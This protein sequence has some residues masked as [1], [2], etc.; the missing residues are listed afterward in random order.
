MKALVMTGPWALE[1]AEIADPA[2]GPG[3]VVVR[4]T[5]TGICGSDFHGFTGDTGRR[6][7]GQVM[8]HETVG[9]VEWVG[10]AVTDPGLSPGALVTINP[11]LS[12]D[13][14]EVCAAGAEQSC[15]NRTVIGVAP[16][17][18]SAFAERVVVRASNVVPLAA[19]LDPDLGALVEPLA[20]GYHAAVRGACAPADRVLVI[21]GGPIGQACLLA[22][23]RLGATAV[24]VS[25]V[26]PLRRD[27]C[28]SF[29]ARV[30]DPLA[31]ARAEGGLGAAVAEALGGKATLVIDAVGLTPTVRDA[32]EASVF[33][34]R[35]VL[36]GMGTP[37]VE[38][39]AYG[40]STE[41]RSLIG[42]FCYSREHF[43]AT[44]T[45]VGE[46]TVPLGRLIDGRVGYD[47]AAAAFTDLAKGST[48]ASKILVYPGGVPTPGESR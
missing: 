40:I 24:A 41:E 5:A 27:L 4:I 16:Q 44:A 2:P 28:A 9:Y 45:W 47:G 25:D 43:A 32:I 21:G 8:G 22:A 26:N 23:Q 14:C 7:A 38:L 46:T 42:S 10:A 35:I 6:H 31:A 37:S 30:I 12:C 13:S 15:P 36:V 29:G 34:A 19:G 18:V 17:L 39:P 1:V 48:D 11:V 20:V 3:D 33:G